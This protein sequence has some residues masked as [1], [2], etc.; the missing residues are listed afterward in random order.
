MIKNQIRKT[1][2]VKELEMENENLRGQVVDL[3]NDNQ[4]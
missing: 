3:E 1:G 4:N 2:M